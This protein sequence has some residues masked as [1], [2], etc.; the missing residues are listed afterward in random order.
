MPDPRSRLVECFR[1][2]FP[3]LNESSA[4]DAQISTIPEWDSIATVTLMALIEE[5]FGFQIPAEETESLHSFETVLALVERS[6][7]A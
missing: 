5:E 2:V 7:V 6:M 3:N 4:L 1:T